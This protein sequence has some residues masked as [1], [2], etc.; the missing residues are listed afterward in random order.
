MAKS[1]HQKQKDRG[2]RLVLSWFEPRKCWKKY[3]DGKTKYFHH[4]NSASGYEAAVAEYHAWLKSLKDDRPRFKEYRHHI[5][6]LGQ[7][8]EWY[9]RFGVPEDEEELQF[10]LTRAAANMQAAVAEEDELL[11][12]DECLPDCGTT[13]EKLFVLRFCPEGILQNGE[14]SNAFSKAFGS[15]GYELPSTWQE[16]VRQLDSLNAN[17]RKQPQTVGHQVQRFLDYHEKR[18]RGGAIKARTWGTLA[19]RLPYFTNW[20]RSGTHVSTIDGTTLTG[21]YEWVLAQD[22][23]G[24][25]RAK[26]IF[27]TAKQWIR[28]AWRQDDVELEQLPRNIDSR[29]FVFLPHI[30]ESGINKKTR[31]ENLWTSEDFASSLA[32]TPEDFQLFLLLML[33]C[34][35]TNTDVA[36]LLKSECNLHE[37]R[38]VRQR[39]KTRRHANPPVVNYKLWPKTL[40]LLKSQWSDHE[41]FA[42]TNR[43]GNPLA[44]SRLEV[45]EGRTHEVQWTGIGRRWTDL[46]RS[47]SRKENLPQKELKFLRKTGSTKL[48]GHENFLTLDSMYL[49]HSYTK[50]SDKHYNAFDGLPFLPLDNAIDWL[51]TQFGQT[52][53]S[54]S[55]S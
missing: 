43:R 39:T 51:G 26:G 4:P 12:I 28:W 9:G 23:W 3:R 20:I 37:G 30:D 40:A 10:A 33:N 46:K 38:I 32:N 24:H 55:K 41:A 29:E 18:A 17:Q 15:I 36:S 16:R 53:I 1:W 27:N 14:P 8:V 13:D 50:V 19:E 5:A 31:T 7:C 6:L 45:K 34:G 54:K 42:L 47:E 2:I 48:K 21:F 52:N 35:F 25:Q 49:G 44:V 22:T 11:P